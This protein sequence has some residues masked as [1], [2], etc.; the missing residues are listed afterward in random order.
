M[1]TAVIAE[2]YGEAGAID[3]YGPADGLPSIVYSGQNQ[4]YLYGP[5]PAATTSP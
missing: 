4:L 3:R 2:N 1:F 5:P